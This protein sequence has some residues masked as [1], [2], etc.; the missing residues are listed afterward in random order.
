[1]SPNC[2]VAGRSCRE[3]GQLFA[4]SFRFTHFKS[5]PA[6]AW[7]PGFFPVMAR[8]LRPAL[9][10]DYMD[11]ESPAN[12][13][14]VHLVYGRSHHAGGPANDETYHIKNQVLS[15]AKELLKFTREFATRIDQD[16]RGSATVDYR[17]R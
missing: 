17:R 10:S 5:H 1:M 4:V 6:A 12:K 9:Y 8:F 11:N 14:V 2:P 3:I 15:F 13:R 16:F 7:G